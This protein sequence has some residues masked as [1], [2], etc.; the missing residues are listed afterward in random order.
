[1]V[2]GAADAIPDFFNLLIVQDHDVDPFLF[3]AALGCSE[4]VAHTDLIA[5][6][7]V[8]VTT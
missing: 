7:F 6:L 8:A 3:A 1:V 2:Q 5:N 4:L